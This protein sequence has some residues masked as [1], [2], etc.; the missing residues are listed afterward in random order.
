M[1][2][3]KGSAL[4]VVLLILTALTILGAAIYSYVVSTSK[5]NNN[6]KEKEIRETAAISALNIGEYYL[7][8]DK[9]YKYI[10]K[11]EVSSVPEDYIKSKLSSN[12]F[13]GSEYVSKNNSLE[14]FNYKIDLKNNGNNSYTITAIAKKGEAESRRNS[15]VILNFNNG[16]TIDEKIDLFLKANSGFT[17]LNDDDFEVEWSV[18]QINDSS[19]NFKNIYSYGN[20]DE[21]LSKYLKDD[22]SF[23]L[24]SFATNIINKNDGNDRSLGLDLN[25]GKKDLSISRSVFKSFINNDLRYNNNV[26]L[27]DGPDG[28][29]YD[30]NLNKIN[31]EILKKYSAALI[32]L[33]RYNY[34]FLCNGDLNITED[35]PD[36]VNL[37][38]YATNSVTINGT[39]W[40]TVGNVFRTYTNNISIIAGNNINIK[41]CYIKIDGNE[42]NI[43]KNKN[44]IKNCLKK[45]TK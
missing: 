3:K 44:E 5:V 8:D 26:V 6:E 31:D 4:I 10:Y 25:F 42:F 17:I 23:S 33:D 19:F 43:D 30:S 14:S 1:K 35:L 13:N 16:P 27:F 15:T 29:F 38:I 22:N 32:R 36:D 9:N 39:F 37:F 12:N 7:I 2:K 20:D 34:V 41:K 18:V 28:E 40:G 11:N 21:Q 45:F 24:L